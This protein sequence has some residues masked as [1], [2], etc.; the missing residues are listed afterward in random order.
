MINLGANIISLKNFLE[1]Q[2]KDKIRLALFN[3]GGCREKAAREL[4][5][6]RTTLIEKIRKYNLKEEDER[7]LFERA[8]LEAAELRARARFLEYFLEDYR[9]S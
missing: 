2:E 3:S 6:N 8:T 9:S 7:P 4:Q 5:M 1:L